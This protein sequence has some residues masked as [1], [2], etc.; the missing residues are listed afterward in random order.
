MSIHL[1]D[2]E[3]LPIISFLVS[4]EVLEK[5][6][7]GL[8]YKK[9]TPE[10]QELINKNQRELKKNLPNYI[11][12]NSYNINFGNCKNINSIFL[13]SFEKLSSIYIR[14]TNNDLYIHSEQFENWQNILTLINHIPILSFFIYKEK[15]QSKIMLKDLD[16]MLPY[17]KDETLIN[18][19]KK[20]LIETHI[21]LNGTSEFIFTWQ[22]YLSN[23]SKSYKTIKT[24][25]KNNP[26]QFKQLG[27]K[28]I[29]TFFNMIKKA[30]Y[31]QE[32]IIAYI[33]S[34]KKIDFKRWKKYLNNNV[35]VLKEPFKF[36][37]IKLEQLK[38]PI[39]LYEKTKN[40]NQSEI[41][42][43]I[44]V[45][46][47]IE[48]ISDENEKNE[49]TILTHYYYLV[50]STFN[51]LLIQQ[52]DQYGFDQ[53]QLITD[54]E[55]RDTYEDEGFLDRYKQLN[56]F[57]NH[58]LTS[59]EGRFAP[60]K[61]VVKFHNLYTRMINDHEV[62]SKD[63]NLTLI[64]HFI[65]KKDTTKYSKLTHR[66]SL[67]YKELDLQANIIVNYFRA[68]QTKY[69]INDY[70]KQIKNF[71][72]IDG[73]GNEL[74]TRPEVFAPT[75]RYM[76][77]VF[78]KE[79]NKDLK[80]TFHAGEDFI[81]IISGIRYIYEAFNYLDMKEYDR[82]GHATA[83]GIKPKFWREKLNSKIVI[84]KGEWLDNLIFLEHFLDIDSLKKPISD[85]WKY[86]YG[87]EAR[88]PDKKTRF[89]IFVARKLNPNKSYLSQQ[90]IVNFN[91]STTIIKYL[92]LYHRYDVRKRYDELES[93]VL[94]SKFDI[95][96]E[97]LQNKILALM[98]DKKIAIETMITSNVRISYYDFYKEHHILNWLS[99][100]HCPD[101][102]L[103]SDDPGIFNNS[104]QIEYTHLFNILKDTNLDYDAICKILKN[105]AYMYT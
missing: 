69:F 77:D 91:L 79:F 60:K 2:N 26:K 67:L 39:Q 102:L 80:F 71:I 36:N 12:E 70:K 34:N 38:H 95:Y 64:A 85:R 30:K 90:N 48:L 18:Q 53:F 78:S 88:L 76:R 29:H 81:H 89:N 72:G 50:Q 100:P 44:K 66:H 58:N 20:D 8:F 74:Y 57:Y 62:F 23:L 83:L 37:S 99:N 104:L 33:Y 96:I 61:S 25:F 21:H 4:T 19:L 11:Y 40:L 15:L 59:L 56:S 22:H 98:K 42:F 9:N 35:F 31:L 63:R 24:S 65:K 41:L 13:K 46:E 3:L 51:K 54:N 75:F 68:T 27:I 73:A 7:S 45:F 28:D 87:E 17:I 43:W 6:N 84:S 47:K 92:K 101:L 5:Y 103:A 94:E 16:S 52:L 10:F 32:F 49:F 1:N 14:K 86:I 97:K 55:I 105:N 93:I 82:I